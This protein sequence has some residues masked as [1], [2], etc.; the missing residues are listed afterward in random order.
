MLE[1]LFL[2]PP[3][4]VNERFGG[5]GTKRGE[6][7]QGLLGDVRR[8]RKECLGGKKKILSSSAD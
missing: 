8:R 1:G 2:R 5:E 6:E 3:V 4:R 7:R